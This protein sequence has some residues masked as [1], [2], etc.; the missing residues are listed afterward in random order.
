MCRPPSVRQRRKG[1]RQRRLRLL[2][3]GKPGLDLREKS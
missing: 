2:D 3:H 1:M